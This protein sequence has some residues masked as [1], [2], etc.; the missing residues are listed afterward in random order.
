M[1]SKEAAARD[2]SESCD[3]ES[4]SFLSRDLKRI[5]EKAYL[6]GYAAAELRGFMR[7]VEMLRSVEA[8]NFYKT[9]RHPDGV[10][11]ADWLEAR[12]P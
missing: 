1:K 9:E 5:R 8:A 10:D 4:G 11:F 3:N 2:Y 7:A 12:K 6:A